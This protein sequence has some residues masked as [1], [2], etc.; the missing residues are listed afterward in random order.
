MYLFQVRGVLNYDHKV[1][2]GIGDHFE[3]KWEEC[4][5]AD[6]ITYFPVFHQE[7]K[8]QGFLRV[9]PTRCADTTVI[10]YTVVLSVNSAN[11]P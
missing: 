7:S 1:K 6:G 2:I 5:P 3:S 10:F 4:I 9:G 11:V 8:I